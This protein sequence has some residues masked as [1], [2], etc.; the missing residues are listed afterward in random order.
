MKNINAVLIAALA[1][2]LMAGCASHKPVEQPPQGVQAQR[3]EAK[4]SVGA[5]GPRFSA[6]V[7]PDSEVRLGFQM[8]R[9]LRGVA[10][11]AISPRVIE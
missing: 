5:A 8:R 7:Q 10:D 4:P 3:I 2:Q 9:S 11:I 6:L 1:A